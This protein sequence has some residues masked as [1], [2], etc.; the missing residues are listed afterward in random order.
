MSWAGLVSGAQFDTGVVGV[1]IVSLSAL[2]AVRRSRLA[3]CRNERYRFTI[4]RWG[5]V[6]AVIAS[7]G[8]TTK[9]MA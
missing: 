3:L 1:L 4:L 6:L 7:I 2:I 5:M 9:F 8:I